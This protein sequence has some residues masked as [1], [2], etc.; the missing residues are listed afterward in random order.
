MLKSSKWSG[1]R[2]HLKLASSPITDE[3]LK[4]LGLSTKGN[5]SELTEWLLEVA[6]NTDHKLHIV[7]TEICT[8]A[9]SA[10]PE[11]SEVELHESPLEKN[12]KVNEDVLAT[13]YQKN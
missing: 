2:K 3:E 12:T 5:K 7:G 1:V 13:N 8:K 10:T 6:G 4:R 9:Q 11:S